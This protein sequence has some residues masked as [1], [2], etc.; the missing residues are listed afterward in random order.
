MVV[1]DVDM[2][3]D[4]EAGE[5]VLFIHVFQPFALYRNPL[6]VYYAFSYP[7][8]PKSMVIGM[9]Q[10]ALGG[11]YYYDD[12]LYDLRIHLYGF[13]LGRSRN[14]LMHYK[15]SDA[16]F[17]LDPHTGRPMIKI[18]SRGDIGFVSPHARYKSLIKPTVQFELFNVHLFIVVRFCSLE[19]VK[20]GLKNALIN[21]SSVLYLGRSGDV[22]F[23]KKVELVKLKDF[24][25]ECFS[26]AGNDI[27]RVSI[28][29]MFGTYLRTDNMLVVRDID[30]YPSYQLTQKILYR[31]LY[32]DGG[33]KR[34]PFIY[35][36]DVKF[37]GNAR[38]IPPGGAIPLNNNHLDRI[39][40]IEIRDVDIGG[41]SKTIQFPLFPEGWM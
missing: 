35:R 23:I 37:L 2:D 24:G 6:T 5:E 25:Y 13:S 31:P 11:E 14:Y 41:I 20:D 27:N 34:R 19:G 33:I 39:K 4:L 15:A 40:W 8:P 22:A 18:K 26:G 3:E 17:I 28:R 29:T 1:G 32:G 30:H 38:Y 12:S 36:D 7:L 10:N 16:R 21:P 9:F